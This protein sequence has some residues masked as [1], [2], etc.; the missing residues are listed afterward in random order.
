MA[1][2][3]ATVAT[4]QS[5][6]T[7][8]AICIVM[9]TT[10]VMILPFAIFQ[11]YR[12]NQLKH[13]HVLRQRNAKISV[14]SSVMFLGVVGI[15][16]P[17][18]LVQSCLAH[19]LSPLSLTIL[20]AFYVFAYSYSQHCSLWLILSR[21]WLAYFEFSWTKATVCV[22]LCSYQQHINIIGKQLNAKWKVH[23]NPKGS[24][25]DEEWFLS[26]K[27][28]Y[29]SL[30]FIQRN[31]WIISIC[32]GTLIMALFEFSVASTLLTAK[33]V[34]IIDGM[35]FIAPTCAILIIWKKM[36]TVYDV[37]FYSFVSVQVP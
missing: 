11:I 4:D 1:F 35:M 22:C 19:L 3:N 13:V 14:A 16:I 20:K 26:N 24:T 37:L 21:F 12:F 2:E 25:K 28:T 29:G 15:A 6:T 23:I 30:R 33:F 8:V 34:Q 32:I 36:P 9:L 18:Y 27:A 17:I 7:R 10:I 31:A 5:P